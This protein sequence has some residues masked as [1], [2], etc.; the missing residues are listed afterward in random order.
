MAFASATELQNSGNS[1]YNSLQVSVQRRAR[2]L[3]FLLT[4]TYAKSLD[5][6]PPRA[7]LA[8]RVQPTARRRSTCAITS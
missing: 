6:V 4:Y 1:N 2:D 7:T 3:T 5:N 8:T